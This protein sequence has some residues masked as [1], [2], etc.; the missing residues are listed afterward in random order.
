VQIL[1]NEIKHPDAPAKIQKITLK[2]DLIIRK[3]CGS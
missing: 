2:T 3:S 1:L